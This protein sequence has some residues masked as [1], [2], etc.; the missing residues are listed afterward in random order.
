[1]LVCQLR[2]ALRGAAASSIFCDFIECMGCPGRLPTQR[3]RWPFCAPQYHRLSGLC[4]LHDA[5]HSLTVGC[6]AAAQYRHSTFGQPVQHR[7]SC[8][9]KGSLRWP[10]RCAFAAACQIENAVTD[11]DDACRLQSLQRSAALSAERGQCP[12]RTLWGGVQTSPCRHPTVATVTAAVAVRRLL[13]ACMSYP[14][15]D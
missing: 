3:T 7:W 14:S 9:A 8:C 1:M 10:I 5:C 2:R 6:T 13:F 15:G 11:A 4:L 12:C